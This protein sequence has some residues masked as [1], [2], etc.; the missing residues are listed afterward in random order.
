MFHD[1]YKHSPHNYKEGFVDGANFMEMLY[2]DDTLIISKSAILTEKL[3]QEIEAESAYYGL[4]LN[5]INA[6]HFS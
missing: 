2:A 5:K 4:A 6:F 1:I 3:I